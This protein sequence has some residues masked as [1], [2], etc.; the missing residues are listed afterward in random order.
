MSVLNWSRRSWPFATAM[1]ALGVLVACGGN[2]KPGNTSENGRAEIKVMLPQNLSATDVARVHVEAQGSGIPSPIGIDL[3]LQGSTWQ[4]TLIDIPAGLDRVFEATAFDAGGTL[5]YQGQAGPMAV[6]SGS[7]VSVVI[8]LQEVSHPPPFDNVA[9]TIDSVVVSANQVSPGGTLTLTVTAHDDN[10]G[11]TLTYAWTGTA[12]TFSAPSA[13]ST[14]WVAPATEGAQQLKIEVKDS[15]GTSATVTID[16]LVQHAGATGNATVSVGFNTWPKVTAMMATPSVLTPNVASQIA[17]VAFDPD[18]DALSFAWGSDCPGFFSDGS[19][20]TPTFTVLAPPP[21][22]NRC[23]LFVSVSD[24]H[25]GQHTGTLA[26]LVGP[27]QHAN[28]APQVDSTSK[29]SDQAGAGEVVTVGLTAHD[30]ESTPLTFT[31]SVN[32]GV[33]LA[34][35]G[36][37]SSSEIDWKAPACLQGPAVLTANIVDAGGATTH[38]PFTITPRSGASC[39]GLAVSGMRNSN[40]ILADG[41]IVITPVDLSGVTVGAWVPTPDGLNYNWRPGAG[42][43]NGTFL[44]PSVESTPYLLQFGSSYLWVTS[45]TLDLS[46]AALGRPDAQ[47]VPDGTQLSLQLSGLSPW[48][49][50]DDVQLHAGNA[51]LGYFSMASCN[52]S[53]EPPADND[54]SL[55]ST[56]DYVSSLQACGSPAVQIDPA[57]GDVLYATQMVSRSDATTGMDFQELRRSVQANPVGPDASGTMQLTGTLTALPTVNQTVNYSAS[58]F[59]ALALASHPTAT[60]LDN[61]LDIGVLPAYGQFGSYAGWPDLA[62][63]D[64]TPA[65]GDIQPSFTYGNPYPASWTPFITAES[66]ARVRYSV[67]L[68]D[69]STSTP[70]SFSVYTY[71]QQP[72]P[73]GNTPITPLVG[74]PT[75]LQL[76]GVVATG[77]L[78]GV[79]TL[80]LLS[81]AVPA[82]GTANYYLV[83]LY[84][85]FATATNSTSRLLVTSFTTAQTQV[86]LPPGVVVPGKFYYAEVDSVADPLA[87]P[88]TPYIHGARYQFAMAV[89]G[90]FQP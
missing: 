71:M 86:R 60:L 79:G 78:T 18:G 59:E 26:L 58:A 47:R 1:L 61:V 43:T 77:N 35:R 40:H 62:Y 64:S 23:T 45:R 29:S 50:A 66:F 5:L 8:M 69:G 4:G 53:F 2:G 36:T 57:R 15:K 89:T 87:N 16:V 65:Q 28:V 32:Q 27:A 72:L 9:P 84:E 82:T 24:G 37:S 48:Q 51:G 80:P 33:I 67:D 3:T 85:L 7:T 75:N 21:M 13:T 39:G 90:R 10:A 76:N 11:D 30:P 42:Q 63:L 55:A 31:W 20:P 6:T 68:P 54:T 22:G 46:G 19:L 17:A 34:T 38:Q 56:F 12:G 88:N 81:W 14:S 83:R 74:P 41:S 73:S 44:I 52:A 25:G 70:R 49:P